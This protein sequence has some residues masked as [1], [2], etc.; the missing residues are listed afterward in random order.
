MQGGDISNSIPGRVIVTYDYVTYDVPSPK[1]IL[2]VVVGTSHSRQVSTATLSLLSRLTARV[3]ARLELAVFGS[4]D[5][6][7]DTIL[8]EMDKRSWQPFNY[9]R[10]YASPLA[11]VSDLPYRPEVLGVIDIDDRMG[12]YGSYGI[13]MDYLARAS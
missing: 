11:L 6:E 10:V 1:K 4:S 7:A 12:A 2:G 8:S 13:S 3:D 5:D 9:A